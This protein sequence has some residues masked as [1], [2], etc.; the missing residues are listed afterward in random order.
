M[1]ITSELKQGKRSWK[2]IR[3]FN[4]ELI[5]SILS[6]FSHQ[7]TIQNHTMKNFLLIRT[8]EKEA[9]LWLQARRHS[10]LKS[11]KTVLRIKIYFIFS[12]GRFIEHADPSYL[13]VAKERVGWISK[14]FLYWVNP[15]FSMFFSDRSVAPADRFGAE[16]TLFTGRLHRGHRFS[17]SAFSFCSFSKPTSQSEQPGPSVHW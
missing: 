6:P 17:G 8:Q 12:Y 14:L 2:F 11:T 10:K 7:V 9:L 13:G 3:T 5:S 4:W 15:C 1:F 16:M